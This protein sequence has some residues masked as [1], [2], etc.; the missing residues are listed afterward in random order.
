MHGTW[1]A[2][3]VVSAISKEPTAIEQEVFSECISPKAGLTVA[4]HQQIC[5]F[6]INRLCAKLS[7]NA[8]PLRF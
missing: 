8:R 1:Q 7:G 3:A 6:C 2:I 5:D 4:Q